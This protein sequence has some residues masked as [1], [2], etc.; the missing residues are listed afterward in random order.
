ML[1]AIVIERRGATMPR[2]VVIAEVKDVQ[3]WLDSQEREGVFGPLGVTE[4]KTYVDIEGSN[5][6]ALTVNIP[7]M[8]AA[9]AYAQTQEAADALERDGVIPESMVRFIES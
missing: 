7:D 5:R 8:D 1:G 9:R 4:V 3:H 6:V 2:V